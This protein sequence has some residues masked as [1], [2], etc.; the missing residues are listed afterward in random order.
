MTEVLIIWKP[1][2]WFTEQIN[3]LVSS[4]MIGTSLM[5]ELSVNIT[6]WSK[7]SFLQTR[8]PQWSFFQFF[9]F[10]FFFCNC[11]IVADRWSFNC[12]YK[13]GQLLLLKIRTTVIANRGRVNKSGQF[14][15]SWEDLLQI[16]TIFIN[17]CTT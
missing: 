7:Q 13:S 6:K 14:L 16:R 11:A 5:K 9:F 12:Y 10:F 8:L 1:V 17:Q 4:Y 3:R 2:H 15:Q